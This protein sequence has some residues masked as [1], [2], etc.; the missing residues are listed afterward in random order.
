LRF[1]GKQTS[2]DWNETSHDPLY[3]Q[4]GDKV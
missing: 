1:E 2:Y 3:F 4:L